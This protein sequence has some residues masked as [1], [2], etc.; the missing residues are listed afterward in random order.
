MRVGV[1]EAYLLLYQSVLDPEGFPEKLATAPGSQGTGTKGCED[2]GVTCTS[3]RDDAEGPC[4]SF[5]VDV[6]INLKVGAFQGH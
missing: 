4:Y 3:G 2:A 1:L 5:Q 6:N